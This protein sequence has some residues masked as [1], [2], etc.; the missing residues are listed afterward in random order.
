MSR[1]QCVYT[2]LWKDDEPFGVPKNDRPESMGGL[3]QIIL[4]T[5]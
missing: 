3:G 5:V 4:K 2:K 1:R